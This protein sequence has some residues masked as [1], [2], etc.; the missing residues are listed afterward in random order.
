MTSPGLPR[1][2]DG[3][4]EAWFDE[5]PVLSADRS[6]GAALAQ[7]EAYGQE[8]ASW[9]PGR[10]VLAIA[11]TLAIIL[12]MGVALWLARAPDPVEP[13]P[14]WQVLPSVEAPL[15]PGR[16]VVG[17]PFPIR[18]GITVPAG[19]GSNPVR[20][21]FAQVTYLGVGGEGG[22]ALFFTFVEGVYADP[23]HLEQGFM[24]PPPGRGVDELAGALAGLPGVSVSGPADTL[25]DGRPAVTLTLTAPSVFQGCTGETDGPPFRLWGVPEWG[26]MVPGQ[27]LQLWIVGIG[28]RRLVIG[29][30]KPAGAAPQ[31]LASVNALVSS[32]DLD[33]EGLIASATAPPNELCNPCA[34][35]PTGGSL[36]PGRYA[37]ELQ[38][39]RLI[40][41][42]P[43]PLS[44][45]HR[46]TF[47]V[48]PGWSS[49]GSGI[50]TSDAPAGGGARL[51]A[52]SVARI[53]VDP[54]HWQ[55]SP[56]AVD[57]GGMGKLD[58]LA[59]GFW[60]WWTT[61]GPL[62]AGYEPPPLA[63]RGTK[64]IDETRY[65]SFAKRLELSIPDDV[66][67]SACDAGEY[68]LWEDVAGRA[69]VAIGPGERIRIWIVD[70]APGMMV[71][72]ASTMP[73]TSRQDCRLLDG[74]IPTIWVERPGDY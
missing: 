38:L 21:T 19:W 53:Y 23:C 6:V 62:G 22:S 28:G 26:S 34:P 37:L 35:L 46:L 4:L 24:D 64:P 55:T 50:E 60:K 74:L 51:S 57:L 16:Y 17:A 11:A 73:D 10:A 8:R 29:A 71:L 45:P 40:G 32:L 44:Q 25:I 14:T 5:G 41:E 9:L 59:D 3:I 2:L 61:G 1:D 39:R 48:Q 56:G 12:T 18:I 52:W 58:A 42:T 30:E 27:R 63:P 31:A 69:R 68:R 70:L 33:P 66:D 13:A 65:G 67:V 15:A 47:D 7:A 49:T 72:E 36:E 20:D 54:C 43:V